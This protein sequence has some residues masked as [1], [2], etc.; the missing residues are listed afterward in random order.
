[1]STRSALLPALTLARALSLAAPPDALAAPPGP[2][3]VDTALKGLQVFKYKHKAGQV[4]RFDSKIEQS[5]AMKG[6]AGALGG[7]A[8]VKTKMTST[9]RMETRK[10]LPNGDAS[11]LTTYEGFDMSMQQGGQTIQGAQL[12]PL[13]E[14]VRKIKTTTTL[15]PNGVQKE[16]VFEGLPPEMEQLQDSFKNAMIGATPVFPDGGLKI[17]QEW[18]QKMPMELKQGPITLKMDFQIKYTFL[19]FTAE[20]ARKVAVF[21][22][23]LDMVMSKTT[24][25]L[26]GVEMILG[27]T[28]SGNG[29]LYFDHEAGR[30]HKS[31]ME[32]D[33]NIDMTVNAPEGP[34]NIKMALK[35]LASVNRKADAIK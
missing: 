2:G 6:D 12:G 27:G 4:E 33:Q 26:M 14:M 11:V 23:R 30:L 31:V 17:G 34:Q 15:A 28:G 9:M 7:A 18:T 25:Q 1:M 13:V 19:G 35:T 29:F 21:K 10:V 20:G 32:M 8:D 3:K 5:I 22:T 24:T 16:V